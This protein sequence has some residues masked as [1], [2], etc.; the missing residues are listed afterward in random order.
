MEIEAFGF[1]FG[2]KQTPKTSKEE[3]GI[4]A[5]TA[6]DRDWETSLISI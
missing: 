6:P 4:Q 2:K 5:F 3:R 1:E